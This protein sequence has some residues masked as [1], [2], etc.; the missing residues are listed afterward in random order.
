MVSMEI[1]ELCQEYHANVRDNTK[2]LDGTNGVL[3]LIKFPCWWNNRHFSYGLNFKIRNLNNDEVGK[4]PKNYYY[5]NG[6]TE[7]AYKVNGRYEYVYDD[8]IER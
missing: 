2:N 1:N 6:T 3:C 8:F 7:R 5:C 4:L